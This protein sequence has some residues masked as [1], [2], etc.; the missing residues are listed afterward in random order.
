MS[1]VDRLREII[2]RAVT[3]YYATRFEVKFRVKFERPTRIENTI[4][5]N[6]PIKT[7]PTITFGT[8]PTR[9][10]SR[11]VHG[12]PKSFNPPPRNHIRHHVAPTDNTVFTNN[13]RITVTVKIITPFF[14]FYFVLDDLT[15]ENISVHEHLPA[16]A[17]VGG[18]RA[19][20]V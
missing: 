4:L 3:Q 17:S 16:Y 13:Y 5:T 9:R 18:F 7:T 15:H 20:G 11:C 1:I 2:T 12:A 19:R 10:R 14:V 8:S 6:P